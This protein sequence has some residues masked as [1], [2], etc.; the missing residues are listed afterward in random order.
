VAVITFKSADGTLVIGDID[1]VTREE[2]DRYLSLAPPR[3]TL[4]VGRRLI[5]LRVEE[6]RLRAL[7]TPEQ[8]AIGWGGHVAVLMGMLRDCAQR[9]ATRYGMASVGFPPA[10][11]GELFTPEQIDAGAEEV[12]ATAERLGMT[13][14]NRRDS[15][16]VHYAAHAAGWRYGRWFSAADQDG[17]VGQHHVACLRPISARQFR[18]ARRD[19]WP[20]QVPPP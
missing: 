14:R 11:Y 3:H 15:E 6:A 12:L 17:D 7:A 2:E 9:N 13:L 10:I 4:D 16:Q 18:A 20:A 5:H 1:H 8:W 19:G